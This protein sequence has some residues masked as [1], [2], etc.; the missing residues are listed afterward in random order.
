VSGR[1]GKKLAGSN[2]APQDAFT[3]SLKAQRMRTSHAS[4]P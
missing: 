4:N 3:P 1:I 2:L